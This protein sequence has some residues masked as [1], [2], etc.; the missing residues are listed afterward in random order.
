MDWQAIRPGETCAPLPERQDA[1]LVFIGRLRTPFASRDECP[2]R[3]DAENGPVCRVEIDE[4]WRG[5]LAGIEDFEQLDL[6]YW[7]NLARRDLLTQTPRGGQPT[8]TFALRSPVRPNPIALSRVRL[9]GIEDGAL[10][11]RGLDCVDGTPLLDIK[12]HH[13]RHASAEPRD[14][15]S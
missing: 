12:P 13:C 10:L 9:L 1:H 8:G 2:R 7:M 3:G 11:V 4:P 14:A 15:A 6:L 5:A